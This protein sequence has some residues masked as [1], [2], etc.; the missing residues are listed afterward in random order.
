[1]HCIFQPYWYG[2]SM[3]ASRQGIVRVCA[4]LALVA[5]CGALAQPAED[6]MA[7]AVDAVRVRLAVR[8]YAAAAAQAEG[9]AAA[10][11]ADLGRYHRSLAEPLM[12][13]GDAR[14]GLDDPDAALQAY[15]RAKHIVRI[16]GGVQGLEQLPF[17]FREA[18]ALVALND[19]SAANDRHEFAFS[20]ESRLY[21]EDDPRRLPSLQRLVDWYRHNYKYRASQVLYEQIIAIARTYYG[22]NDP[23]LIDALRGY[24]ATY[25]ERRF[26][27]RE[28]GRGGFRAWPPGSPRDP[29]WYQKSTFRRGRNALR[30]VLELTEA[31]D[32]A[33]DVDVA[34]AVVELAD[35]NLL[36][37]EY[38]IAMRHYRR[39]WHLL[40]A[41]P[42]ER[43]ATFEVPTALFLR[44]PAEPSTPLRRRG[45]AL[46]GVV[47][48]ALNIT[49]RGDVV[50]RRTLRAEPRNLMEFKVRQA[51]KLARYRPAFRDGDPV[52]RRR[53]NLEFNYSYYPGA[54]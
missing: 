31:S 53:V 42:P 9:L 34:A 10:V 48:L 19:R 6:A 46:D 35:W 27:T 7:D 30:E 50:G 37:H 44:L 14:M 29:P 17:L 23:R 26:G 16:D 38:G 54:D 4:G 51:A 18:K 21:P 39:A 20:L 28:H 32:A 13:L 33:T 40:E 36:H 24:A 3:A 12:L 5:A 45:G 1:M 47:Q 25:R 2:A 49:H 8:E 22:E 15:D 52:P 11:E 41:H 43:R